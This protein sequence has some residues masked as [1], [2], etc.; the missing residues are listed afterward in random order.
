MPE[1]IDITDPANQELGDS[2][3]LNSTVL[4]KRTPSFLYNIENIF[5]TDSLRI[6]RVHLESIQTP[7]HC[8]IYFSHQSTFSTLFLGSV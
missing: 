1:V 8:V 6:Y 3:I 5:H 2:N 7:S 4:T